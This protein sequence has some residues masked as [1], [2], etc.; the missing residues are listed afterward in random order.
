[1]ADLT[2]FN[3]NQDWVFDKAT[4]KSKC[5]NSPLWGQKLTGK[6]VGVFS[7]GKYYFDAELAK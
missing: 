4:N 7:N 6:A 1:M 5:T 3:P 2:L